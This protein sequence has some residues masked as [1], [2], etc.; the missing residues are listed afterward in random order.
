MVEST[1]SLCVPTHAVFGLATQKLNRQYPVLEMAM[2]MDFTLVVK[3]PAA[4][5]AGTSATTTIVNGSLHMLR[6]VEAG[7]V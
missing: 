2:E 7:D 3:A 4:T 1:E 5:F 6:K